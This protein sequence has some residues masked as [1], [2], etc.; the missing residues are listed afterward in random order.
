HSTNYRHTFIQISPD[1][2]A[3]TGL[4]PSK[5]GTIADL[6]LALIRQKPYQLT[7]DDLLFTVHAIRNEITEELRPAAREEFFATPKACLRASPLVKQ[8]GWGIHHDDEERIAAYPID[9]DDYRR[10]S[11]SPDVKSVSGM[12]SKRS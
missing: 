8:F 10:L 5:P 1:S 7:S 2:N 3:E 11:D 12:R 6:Q 4:T 9:S